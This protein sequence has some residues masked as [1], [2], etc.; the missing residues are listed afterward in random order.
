MDLLVQNSLNNFEA[1]KVVLEK[2]LGK[3][4]NCEEYKTFLNNGGDIYLKKTQA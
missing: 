1:Y 4:F 2:K 3:P